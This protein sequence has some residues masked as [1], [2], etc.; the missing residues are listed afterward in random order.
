MN[1]ANL[2][3]SLR[4]A[5]IAA[6]LSLT[7]CAAKVTKH[8]NMFTA[9]DIEQVQPGMSK[10][11]VKLALGTPATTSAMGGGVYYYM[12]TTTEQRSFFKPT[13]TDRKVAAIYF[14]D[15][16]S[17][18]RV[19]N[20]GLKDGKV[21]DLITRETPS[22]QGDQGIIKQLFRNIGRGAERFNG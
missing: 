11:Q 7:A 9:A 12:S 2:K 17:V 19:A 16:D 14:N 6:T 15:F 10:E 8:G 20:Y 22:H 18:D 4:I 3:T 13:I 21:I 1:S 5:A